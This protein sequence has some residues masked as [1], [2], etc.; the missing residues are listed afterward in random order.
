[1]FCPCPCNLRDYPVFQ[2]LTPSVSMAI[3]RNF[4]GDTRVPVLLPESFS[5]GNLSLAP[6]ASARNGSLLALCTR[7]NVLFPLIKKTKACQTGEKNFFTGAFA[8][9]KGENSH[10][11]VLGWEW[12]ICLQSLSPRVVWSHRS[13]IISRY[14]Q[15]LL[16]LKQEPSH[17]CPGSWRPNESESSFG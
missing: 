5:L 2:G 8:C 16:V 17:I 9:P 6:S 13:L 10:R 15:F 4:P 11:H 3:A 14:D 1:L 12:M 7:N